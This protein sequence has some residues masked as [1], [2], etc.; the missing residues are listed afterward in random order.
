LTGQRFLKNLTLK[1]K[2]FLA[3]GF[4]SGYA[5]AIPGTA[6]SLIAWLLFVLI[7]LPDW[8]W[9][10]IAILFVFAGLWATSAIEAAAGKDPGIVV[11]DE[12]A[13]QWLTLLFLPRF[14]WLMLAG[15]FLFRMLDILKPF[16]ANKIEKL[17][18][19]PGIML[20]DL[21]AAVYSNF[22]LQATA[23]LFIY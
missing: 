16:P 14:F 6:G 9:L 15:F 8:L 10:V 3:T 13:G 19:A 22:L 2:Y 23:W 5:P 20:D 1:V 4:G 17:S 11:I 18:G 12:I 7:P 21:V